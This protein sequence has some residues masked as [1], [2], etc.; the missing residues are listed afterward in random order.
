[1]PE[2]YN[3]NLSCGNCSHTSLLHIPLGITLGKYAKDADCPNCGC[4]LSGDIHPGVP[5]NVSN[6][7]LPFGMGFRG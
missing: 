4:K 7:I 3:Q 2:T 5:Y 6:I 1:M